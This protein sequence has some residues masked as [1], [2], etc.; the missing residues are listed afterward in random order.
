M[1]ERCMKE[2]S[3]M[4]S[5]KYSFETEI[6]LTVHMPVQ[7]PITCLHLHQNTVP[8]DRSSHFG[9]KWI[10]SWNCL[11][12]DCK[13]LYKRKVNKIPRLVEEDLKYES[14]VQLIEDPKE[15]HT[16]ERTVE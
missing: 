11:I 14:N 15:G 3:I 6:F 2:E 13:D 5:H 9:K 8:L 12:R 4:E 1:I 16:I 7:E 10:G